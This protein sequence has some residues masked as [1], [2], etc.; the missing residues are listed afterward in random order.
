M[1]GCRID[2]AK[3]ETLAARQDGDRNLA[4][5]GRRKNKLG[6]R[7]RFFQRL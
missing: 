3:V 6:V 2:A 1:Q 5:L 7:R 4:D